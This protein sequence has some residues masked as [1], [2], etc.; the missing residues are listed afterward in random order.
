MSEIR[1]QILV[2]DDEPNNHV[3]Y[4]RILAPLQLELVKVFSG[5]KALSMAHKHDFFL[6]LMDANMPNMDGFETASLILE[7]PKTSHIPIIFITAF[8]KD[9]IFEFKGY[10]SGA[11]DYMT[12]PIN[13]E[14][15][16]QKVGGFHQLY[17]ERTQLKRA[18]EKIERQKEALTRKTQDL[19][20]R[21]REIIA[22]QK[23]LLLSEKLAQ[24]GNLMAGVAH[25]LNN[26]V[27]LVNLCIKNLEV[28]LIK[29]RKFIFALAGEDAEEA[30]LEQFRLKFDP[31]AKHVALI[32]DGSEQIKTIVKD[33]KFSSSMND[34]ELSAVYIT[35]NINSTLNL[36]RT[37]YKQQ[38]ELI[39]DFKSNPEI[40]CYPAK[41][42][43]VFMNLVVNACH[44]LLAKEDKDNPGEIIGQIIA[45]CEQKGDSV[46]IT[47]KDN[48]CG[49]TEETK[50]HLF[51][52]FYTT[53]SID[54]GTGLGLSISYDIVHKHGGELTV[55]SE[56]DVG[57][58]FTLTLPV[59]SIVRE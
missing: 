43:Q 30:I 2:V 3:V 14:V 50:N 22:T 29:C 18:L 10:A 27:N 46:E 42:N 5:Q 25:E 21:N 17:C 58:V 24:L 7:H 45:G 41:L 4:D 35:D 49:M 51:E 36:V 8:T 26:P 55:E 34:K 28:D 39:T 54:E 57:T 1:P 56:L 44:A 16:R 53:K 33:L 47:I 9:E 31:L 19:E 20:Q 32:E 40:I 37:K 23:K 12:K 15:L 6:I 48:G 38:V 59:G 52:P 13:D 11:V